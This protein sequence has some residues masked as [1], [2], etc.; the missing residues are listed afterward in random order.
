M[1]IK[2]VNKLWV[3]LEL[4]VR[5]GEVRVEGVPQTVAHARK[6]GEIQ[7]PPIRHITVCSK[8]DCDFCL[9][10]AWNCRCWRF[11][12][13]S[14][15]IRGRHWSSYW[16]HLVSSWIAP[17][18]VCY[19]TSFF[20]NAICFLI[21][22][23]SLGFADCKNVMPVYIGDDRTDEDAFKVDTSATGRYAYLYL[24]SLR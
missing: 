18:C 15:G 8:H 10:G 5:A 3:E 1:M 7:W 4:V 12:P 24:C 9:F 23:S 11:V 19:I 22:F 14:T 6:K 20:N 13:P 16:S 2:F 17:A 21:S